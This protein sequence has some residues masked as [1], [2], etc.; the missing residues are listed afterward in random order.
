[1]Q[2]FEDV[3]SIVARPYVVILII[4]KAESVSLVTLYPVE[5]QRKEDQRA[6]KFG[7]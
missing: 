4:I 6:G 2:K 7:D 1:M 3:A 5:R